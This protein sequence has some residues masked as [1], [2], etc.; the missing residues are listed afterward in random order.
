[1]NE[2]ERSQKILDVMFSCLSRLHARDRV[3]VDREEFMSWA[4][5]QLIACGVDVHPQGMSHAVLSSKPDD[6]S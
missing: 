1:M 2:R 6:W 5:A 4:R 3:P